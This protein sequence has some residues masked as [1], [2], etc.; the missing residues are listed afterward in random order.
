M[1]LHTFPHGASTYTGLR[2]FLASL[3]YL[4]SFSIASIVHVGDSHDILA[5]QKL[6]SEQQWPLKGSS[7][8]NLPLDVTNIMLNSSTSYTA[9]LHALHVMESHFFSVSEGTWPDAIDWTAAL[10]GTQVSASLIAMSEHDSPEDLTPTNAISHENNINRYFTQLATFYFGQDAFSLRT[11]AYDDMLWVVLGWIESIKFINK[12]SRLHYTRAQFVTESQD[13]SSSWYARQFIPQFAHRSR[14]FYD[15]ATKG[16]DTTLCGGGMIWNS[17]RAPYKNA[18]TNQ[19]FIAASVSMYLDFPGDD[20]PSPFVSSTSFRNCDAETANE[21]AVIP[22]AKAH[23]ERYKDIA[24]NAY[25]WLKDSGMRNAAGLYVDGFH[26]SGWR[27][28]HNGSNGSGKCDLRAETV[29][30]YNQGVILTA[31]RG[32]WEATGDTSYLEDGHELINDV[33]K[34]TG[35]DNRDTGRDF[36]WAGLGRH[37]I[38]EDTCD[39]SG[40]CSQDGQT[41]KGIFWHHFTVFCSPLPTSSDH[42]DGNDGGKKERPWLG[43]EETRTL[44][45]QSCD[46]YGP[47]ITANAQAAWVTRDHAGEFGGWWGRR[48]PGKRRDDG[49][50]ENGY[51]MDEDYANQKLDAPSKSDGDIDYRNEGVPNDE[52]W[53]LTTADDTSYIPDPSVSQTQ[54]TGDLRV[55]D[56]SKQDLNDRG[57]GRTVET[58]SGGVAV[59][60]ALWK[61]VESRK[62]RKQ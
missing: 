62:E 43:D 14:L 27:G 42:D 16:W 49:E 57:R 40:M 23:D 30:T 19:L 35:W 58:Q 29:Y 22:P 31:L 38:M 36:L 60:R 3:L 45:Q 13:A 44:H 46:R 39:W 37:G 25:K 17:H 12:H 53:R 47:W 48:W 33:I 8:Q 41:F 7:L 34:A 51:A 15:L 61:L 1:I 59:M 21:G 28:G 56:A 9:L 55:G 4:A 10:V 11:Q 2:P 50:A 54:T 52:I 32:L 5:R 26:I 18:I 20:N 24:I 6:S